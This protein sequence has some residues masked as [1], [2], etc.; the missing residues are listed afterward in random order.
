MFEV[1]HK[2]KNL[3]SLKITN[4][5]CFWFDGICALKRKPNRIGD[6]RHDKTGRVDRSKGNEI[7][8]IGEGILHTRRR[9]NCKTGL[10]DTAG[11]NQ[12]QQTALGITQELSEFIHFVQAADQ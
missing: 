4:Q 6:Y 9:F 12:S 10:A 8:T 3:L 1:I 11:A 5:L 7:H 2:E